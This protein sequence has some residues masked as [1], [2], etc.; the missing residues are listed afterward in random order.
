SSFRNIPTR[1]NVRGGCTMKSIALLLALAATMAVAQNQAWV[2]RY[3]ERGYWSNL[4]GTFPDTLSMEEPYAL[5]VDVSGHVYV[6]GE[7][8][9][10]HP[11]TD[12]TDRKFVTLKYDPAGH[13]CWSSFY[14][15]TEWSGSVNTPHSSTKASSIAVDASH[16]VYITGGA[17]NPAG[18]DL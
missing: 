9:L 18:T 5:A 13:L 11:P 17:Y 10:Y 16:N 3:H 1:S 7:S 6:L 14:N 2:A 12:A 8:N 15:L 4:P